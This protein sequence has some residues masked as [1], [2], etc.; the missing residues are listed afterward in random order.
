[1]QRRLD[2]EEMTLLVANRA[3]SDYA[4]LFQQ[5]RSMYWILG[6]GSYKVNQRFSLK[7]SMLKIEICRRIWMDVV[8]VAFKLFL[9]KFSCIRRK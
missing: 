7:P 4:L 8:V 1:M 5:A 2:V 3:V 9:S 6:L